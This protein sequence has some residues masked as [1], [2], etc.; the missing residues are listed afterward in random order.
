MHLQ[1]KKVTVLPLQEAESH[2]NN[3]QGEYHETLLACK[4]Q[5]SSSSLSPNKFSPQIWMEIKKNTE[6]KVNTSQ[7]QRQ[8]RANLLPTLSP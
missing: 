2:Y 5:H 1:A 3:K 8:W 4:L 6:E 7:H